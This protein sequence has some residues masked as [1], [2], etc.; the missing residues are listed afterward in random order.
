MEGPSKCWFKKNGHVHLALRACDLPMVSYVRAKA[1]VQLLSL[2]WRVF[3]KK[4]GGLF[5][6]GIVEEWE[7]HV[8]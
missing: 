2:Y 4:D 3:F 6:V 5:F 8:W 1:T 7:G